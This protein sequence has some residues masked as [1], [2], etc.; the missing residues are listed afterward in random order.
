[1]TET[2]DIIKYENKKEA[3]SLTEAP[4]ALLSQSSDCINN[5]FYIYI[6]ISNAPPNLPHMRHYT[7]TTCA[8]ASNTV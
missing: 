1:M 4:A 8:K 7:A 5:S 2:R 6:Y 3:L